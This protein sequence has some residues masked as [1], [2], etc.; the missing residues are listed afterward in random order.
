M[1]NIRGLLALF[2]VLLLFAQTG[3][4]GISAVT[5]D[6]NNQPTKYST[7]YNSGTRDIIANTLNG[8]GASAYY[9][10]NYQYDTL[11]KQ[12]A[13]NILNSLRTLMTNTH[14]KRSSYDDCHYMA[15]RTDCENEDGSVSLIYTGYSATMDQ[16]YNWN[17]NSGWNREHVW[18]QSLGGNN[19]TGGGADLHHIRP[20]D[21]IV[22]S[23]RG[24]KK[25][26]SVT[27]GTNVYGTKLAVGCLGGKYG[28][29]FEPNDNVKGDVARICLY[30]YVRWGSAW[31][32]SDITDVFQSV[33][34]LLEWCALDPVD[35]WELGRNEVVQDIQGNRN[36][37][38]D[39]P[40]YAWLIFG[41][42]VPTNLVSPTSGNSGSTTPP[43]PSVTEPSVTEPPVTEPQPDVPF[44]GTGSIDFS[45]A[46]NRVSWDSN[47]QT[48]KQDGIT[49]VNDKASSTVGIGSYADPAR[50]YANTK[51]TITAPGMTKIAFTCNSGSYATA[52]KNSITDS[53]IY[54]VSLSGSVVTVTFK[55]AVDSFV[56]DKL[57]EQVRVNS[58][59]IQ[60]ESSTP[61]DPPVTDPTVPGT[62]TVPTDPSGSGSSESKEPTGLLAFFIQ[63]INAILA[64]FGLKL[65][66]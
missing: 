36:V 35:T 14:T 56:V 11:S 64:I 61:V 48:W 39:Y 16:W 47:Q 5:P 57:S 12:S 43:E 54:T 28:T 42:S 49:L 22:N 19:T 18:P 45:K 38:I 6:A 32:A 20:S 66:V 59:S 3:I 51:L 44:N 52:L 63:I 4:L 65:V 10:G 34:V 24:N 2:L 29:Y 1:K 17:N 62:P 27:G 41:R 25:Y 50:F 40:E 31:G 53:N 30:V 23:T 8:T 33:D 26:G 9:T 46:A 7:E 58:L 13:T 60:A 15:N 37:F 21:P 55:E